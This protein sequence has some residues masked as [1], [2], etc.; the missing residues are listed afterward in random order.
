MIPIVC[1]GNRAGF[2][3]KPP[4]GRLGPAA[5]RRGALIGPALSFDGTAMEHFRHLAL[6]L[7][8]WRYSAFAT[9]CALTCRLFLGTGAFKLH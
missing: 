3:S 1:G 4:S 6:T 9:N 8:V 2:C 7:L 5:T